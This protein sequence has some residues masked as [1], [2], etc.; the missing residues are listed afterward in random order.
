MSVRYHSYY[1]QYENLAFLLQ[2]REICAKEISSGRNTV[3][4]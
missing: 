4:H 2:E 3:S 1:K